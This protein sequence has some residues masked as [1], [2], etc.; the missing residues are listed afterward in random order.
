MLGSAILLA[1]LIAA[2]VS[3]ILAYSEA[4]E[5]QDDL[6]RQIAVLTA[7]GRGVSSHI[8][9]AK[10][11]QPEIAL[12]DPES[13]INV[14]HLPEAPPP[15]WLA[16]NVSP[17]THTLETAEG[18][19]RVF[20]QQDAPGEVTVV[21]QP[22][23]T[24]DEIA[25]NS[26]LRTFAPLLLLLPVM[27]W[28]IMRIVRQELIPIRNL[29][30]HLDA[31]PADHPRP[32]PVKDVPDEII[33]FVH[34]INRLLERVNNLV[35]QQRRF[36]ADAA[37]EL[38]S[39]LTALSL[40]VQ[41]LKQAGSTEDLSDR[42]R[43]LQAG[44]ERARK[45]TEQLL[46]LA[47]MQ[48]GTMDSTTIDVST[49]ARKLI[50]EYLPMAAAKGIDLGLDE[51]AP[52]LLAASSD[53]I[54]LILKNA[55]ENALKYTPIGGEVTLR[56]YSV[57]DT[58][59]LEVVDNGPG[60]SASERQRVFDPFYRIPGATGEGSGLGLAIA[61]EAAACQ[62]GKV[63]LLARKSGTGLIFRYSQPRSKT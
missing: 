46:N 41:N 43:S 15:E 61:R 29:S 42:I 14:I 20:L 34:A 28:L 55:L 51:A 11:H 9:R 48:T 32:L 23:D 26:A 52:L 33:P 21:T 54:D 36:I 59:L 62:G 56:L 12:N 63:S 22:T 30:G 57:D 16:E 44:L 49:I 2:L 1:G 6:L 5:F 25:L 13:R 39:P 8:E 10:D 40:Q 24:R 53:N 4:K 17:G 50:A 58:A 7:R 45:L 18:R 35:G 31:Q 37:H 27:A 47:R 60:I 38:R 19:L 3:F